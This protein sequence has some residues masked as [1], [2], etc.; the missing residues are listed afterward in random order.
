MPANHMEHAKSLPGKLPYD[1]FSYRNMPANHMNRAKSLPGN[2][3]FQLYIILSC[4]E[5]GYLEMVQIGLYR[6]R[7]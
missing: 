7:E 2:I 6:P 4:F 1:F 3:E 5:F